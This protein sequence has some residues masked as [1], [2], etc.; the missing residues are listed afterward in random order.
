VAE[1]YLVLILIILAL[2]LFPSGFIYTNPSTK[3]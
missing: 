2:A 3:G 1:E